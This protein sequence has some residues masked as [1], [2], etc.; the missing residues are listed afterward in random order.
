MLPF[1]YSALPK[2]RCLADVVPYTVLG[3]WT[4]RAAVLENLA[5]QYIETV[6]RL[7][8][9]MKTRPTKRLVA[10]MKSIKHDYD[11]LRQSFVDDEGVMEETVLAEKFEEFC[12]ED[13]RKLF[14]GLE[15][16]VGKLG[17]S[18]DYKSLIVAVQQALTVIEAALVY[19]MKCNRI[20][21]LEYDFHT[22]DDFLIR[23]PLLRAYALMPQFAGDCYQPN[24]EARRLTASIIAN[25]VESI[26]LTATLNGE[27]IYV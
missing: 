2:S 10:A 13:F 19:S 4:N 24:I 27:T 6:R 5:W 20:L 17:L 3:G 12:D 7:C 9:Q 21:K 15:N 8:I 11:I 18:P 23:K 16:E 14:Y 1:Y 26:V 22:D 25:R